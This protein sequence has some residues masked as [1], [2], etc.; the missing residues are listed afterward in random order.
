MYQN[1]VVEKIKSTFNV[2]FFFF[3]N[4]SVYGIK[5]KNSVESDRPKMTVWSMRIACW[6]PNATN[7][8][9]EYVIYIALPRQQW[10]HERASM[11]R[12]TGFFF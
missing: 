1:K 6:I 8:H 5:R 11:L 3:E 7:M 10:L 4:L 2:Q 12:F 9:S